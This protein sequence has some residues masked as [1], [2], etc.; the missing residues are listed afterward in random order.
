MKRSS[1]K[2]ILL[3]VLGGVVLFAGVL[4]YHIYSV[5]RTKNDFRT[6]R[7]LGRIDFTQPIDSMQATTLRYYVAG[8]P[9]VEST[10][11]NYGSNILVY[12]YFPDQQSSENVF[13]A[14]KKK[15]NYG[16][17]KYQ[18]NAVDLAKGCPV[19]DNKSFTYRA[20]TFVSALFR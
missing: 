20:S 16:A 13:E 15:G 9:G 12:S 4:M 17:R 18:V 19:I 2:K 10:F 8:L 1:I 6:S 3:S 5:T 14:V 11:F 7:Q